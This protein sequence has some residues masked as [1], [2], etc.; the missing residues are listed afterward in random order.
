MT[1]S[2]TISSAVIMSVIMLCR[3][4]YWYAEGHYADCLFMN[5]IML[6]VFI[7]NVIM[8]SVVVPFDSRLQF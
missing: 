2:I 5:A 3:I 4:F 6:K 8:L 1:L 7:L